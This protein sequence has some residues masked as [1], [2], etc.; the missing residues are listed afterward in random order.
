M[1]WNQEFAN[2]IGLDVT[3]TIQIDPTYQPVP[4][5]PQRTLVDQQQAASSWGAFAQNA[6]GSLI[7]YQVSKDAA[8]TNAQL[9]RNS[10]PVIQGTQAATKKP[11]GAGLLLVIVIVVLVASGGGK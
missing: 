9:L 6:I 5:A 2:M 8:Q 10:Y 4:G 3:D 1:D 7:K 11:G